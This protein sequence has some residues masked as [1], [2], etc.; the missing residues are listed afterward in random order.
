MLRRRREQ[1]AAIQTGNSLRGSPGHDHREGTTCHFQ[2]V[3][4]PSETRSNNQMAIEKK[5]SARK[6]KVH[7][8]ETSRCSC[9]SHSK[10]LGG[11]A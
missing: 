10:P 9:Y 3:R 5:E 2:Q 6:K 11:E 4:G 8:P 7:N 1:V